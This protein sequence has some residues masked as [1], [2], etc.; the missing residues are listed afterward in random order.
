M[1]T[2]EAA[3]LTEQYRGKRFDEGSGTIWTVVN[4]EYT[5]VGPY[6]RMMANYRSRDVSDDLESSTLDEV[7]TWIKEFDKRPQDL[8]MSTPEPRVILTVGGQR[9]NASFAAWS[10]RKTL[11]ATLAVDS[12]QRT[13]GAID[14]D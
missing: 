13:R 5:Q 11:E 12:S 4:V 3:Q 1:G 14:I 10:T 6:Y 2:L 9:I 7:V 8:R